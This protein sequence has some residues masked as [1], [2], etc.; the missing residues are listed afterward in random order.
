MRHAHAVRNT[1]P[2]EKSG[3]GTRSRLSQKVKARRQAS[4]AS[5]TYSAPVSGMSSSSD[6]KRTAPF[7]TGH[8]E[9]DAS[10][11]ATAPSGRASSESTNMTH[12]PTAISRPRFLAVPAPAF[13]HRTSLTLES[14]RDI[15]STLSALESVDPSS[16]TIISRRSYD[17]RWTQLSVLDI[18]SS[19]L[20]MGIITLTSACGLFW[21]EGSTHLVFL[22]VDV[23]ETSPPPELVR[24]L[25]A[26]KRADPSFDV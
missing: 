6:E 19:E 8:P 14:L 16:T 13:L 21:Q 10:K 1:T 4:W 26:S 23:I 25:Q 11:Q 12:S 7:T 24:S 17:C 2:L 15:A 18:V 20:N 22:E 9:C 5:N 3:D